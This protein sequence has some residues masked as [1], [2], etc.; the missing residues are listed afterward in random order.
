MTSR[1]PWKLRT[2]RN[3]HGRGWGPTGEGSL[4]WHPGLQEPEQGA[5]QKEAGSLERE[6]GLGSG[7][8]G[9]APPPPL[10]V[11]TAPSKMQSSSPVPLPMW[12]WSGVMVGQFSGKSPEQE[13]SVSKADGAC[14]VSGRDEGEL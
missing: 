5:G 7:P 14:R 13:E 9:H 2:W 10:S 3:P 6:A 12:V 4:A 1:F 8:L 11:I